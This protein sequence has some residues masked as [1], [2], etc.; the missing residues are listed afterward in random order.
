MWK[1]HDRMV[2]FISVGSCSDDIENIR[3]NGQRHPVLGRHVQGEKGFDIELIYGAR[4][5]FIAE[6]LGIKLKMEIRDDISD[7]ECLI[8]MDAENRDRRDISPYE[9]GISYRRWIEEGYSQS[10]AEIARGIGLSR[11]YVNRLI[12]IATLPPVVVGAFGNPQSMKEEWGLR[13]ARLCED[14]ALKYKMTDI[15]RKIDGEQSTLNPLEIYQRLCL[16]G[17]GSGR[18]RSKLSRVELVR[19]SSGKPAF[20]VKYG[21]DSVSLVFPNS[22]KTSELERLKTLALDLTSCD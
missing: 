12:K 3:T 6:Y 16:A 13:L 5:R 11:A 21:R 10:Q 20:R 15:A 19:N 14:D 8:E 1:M 7:Q 4:R 2:D 17:R 9:R 18:K 22:I